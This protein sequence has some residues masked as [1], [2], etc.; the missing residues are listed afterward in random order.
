MSTN[1]MVGTISYL[2]DDNIETPD[3]IG[4]H[5]KQLDWLE[6]IPCS[7]SYYRVESGW[8]ADTKK[9][10]ETSL[11][12]HSIITGKHFPGY[13]RNLLLEHF[14]NTDLDWLVCLDDD[15][16]VQPMYNANEFFK[17]LSSKAV[18]SLAERGFVITTLSPDVEPFKKQ[19]YEW[20]YK[21]THWYFTRESGF[22]FM[23]MFFLPNLVK[24]GYKPI[25]FD[26]ETS[27]LHDAVPEDEKFQYDLLL[28]KHRIIK[29]RNIILREAGN[30]KHS[31]IFPTEEYRRQCH[32]AHTEWSKRYIRES[33]PRNTKLQT[34]L[35]LAKYR[36][37]PFTE[38]IP[39]STPYEF[40]ANEFPKK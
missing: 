33:S 18:L 3:R 11:D 20:T 26:G 29:N 34:R 23:Q 31:S 4:Y 32:N 24:Y 10:L 38:L 37:P 6:S 14:Y 2:P 40:S 5:R 25:Y 28:H 12:L 13:N 16:Y 9:A 15:R 39:R 19:N 30:G 36:N 35:G 21:N 27:C 17:D 1:F 8:S 22:G 7:F